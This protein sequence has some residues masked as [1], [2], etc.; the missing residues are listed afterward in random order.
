M[1]IIDLNLRPLWTSQDLADAMGG[2]ASADF[3][4][5]G[6]SYDSREVGEGDLFVALTGENTDGHRFIDQA[7]GRKAAGALVS[8][9]VDYPHILVDDTMRA[10]EDL[11]R[12]SRARTDAKII[13]VTGSAGKTGTKEAL[14]AALDRYSRGRAH[15]SVK[16]Y[17]NH[18]G[19]PL[20]LA[21][22]PTQ[23]RFGILE[24][25]M[26]H[27]GEL[28]ALTQIVRPDVAIVTTIAP[29]HV[30]FFRDEAQIAEAK[31]EIFEGLQPGGVAII[32]FDNPHY[33]IL[34]KKA[35]RHAA[36]V[37][38]FGFG[39]GADVRAI[40]H[41]RS[42]D[43]GSLVTAKVGP[44][45]L[46]YTVREP[47]RHWIA[48]SLA[49]LAAVD[50]VGGDLAMAGLALAELV[51][52]PGRG[53]RHHIDVRGGE[54]LLIDESYNANPASMAATIAELGREPSSRHLVCLG[55]MKELGDKSAEYHEALVEPLEK[56]K[57]DF[58]VLVGE[59]M[60]P[61]AR[62]LA[63]LSGWAG[64]FVHCTDV[65]QAIAML[66]QRLGA[67]DALLVKGSNAV[68]LSRLV[69]VLTGGEAR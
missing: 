61:L 42:A 9:P 22:M 55:E 56:A 19:V 15:R 38:T 41:I 37:V 5:G 49:L 12:A 63:D 29:A 25:G 16:S 1:T 21:R 48:N 24:M 4:V 14:F 68:G 8:R 7:F 50:V 51:E 66:G 17:N 64:K 31:A 43:G 6:V 30:G 20:S 3:V 46:V 26:N 57:I 2:K 33:E 47:G 53:A 69:D 54:L 60:R 10:L 39:E 36:T 59:E 32:P 52:M 11:A 45:M 44:R 40:D 62:R 13:G 65:D 23:T 27:V 34:R 18:V 35:E 58:A 67:G 28:S